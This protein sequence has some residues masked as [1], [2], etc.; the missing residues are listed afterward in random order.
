ML[1]RFYLGLF[2]GASFREWRSAAIFLL[3]IAS[4]QWISY[5]A[6]RRS[7]ALQVFFGLICCMAIA[8][9]LIYSSHSFFW[10]TPYPDGSN[11]ITWRSGLLFLLLLAMTQGISFLDL[12]E[13]GTDATFPDLTYSKVYS[14]G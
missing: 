5:L 7:I 8:G 4:A 12:G 13:M 14:K 10:E 1:V 2:A 11:P 6:F 3:L 9:Y